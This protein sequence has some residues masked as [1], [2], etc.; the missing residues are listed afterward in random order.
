MTAKCTKQDKMIGKNIMQRRKQLGWSR[1]ELAERMNRE[2]SGQQ[3]MKYESGANRC[4][5]STL[6]DIANAMDSPITSFYGV[7]MLEPNLFPDGE[8]LL[9]QCYQRIPQNRQDSF[10]A[11]IGKMIQTFMVDNNEAK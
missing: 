8:Q 9:L 3:V 1:R 10:V 11:M 7:R 5:A 6:F 2:I 4:P